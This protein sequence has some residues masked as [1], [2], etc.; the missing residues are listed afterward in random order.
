MVHL[1]RG[2]FWATLLIQYIRR[3]VAGLVSRAGRLRFLDAE[4]ADPEPFCLTQAE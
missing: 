4:L 1:C 3:P 2:F